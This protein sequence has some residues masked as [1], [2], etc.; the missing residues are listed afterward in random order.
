MKR[1][2][3]HIGTHKTGTTSIQ[4]FLANAENHLREDGILY[5]Q[6]GRPNVE[7]EA[8]YGHHVLAWAIRKKKGVNH[9]DDWKRVIDEID[10]AKEQTVVLS[11]ED[12]ETCTKEQIAHIGVLLESFE[13]HIVLFLRNPLDFLVSAYKQNIKSGKTAESFDEFVERRKHRC[14]YT[15][16]VERW[17][18]KFGTDYLHVRVFEK[19][20]DNNVEQSI[21]DLLEL[22]LETYET[23]MQQLPANVS[24][25]DQQIALV[26]K[27]NKMEATWGR[28]MF[29]KKLRRAILN[30]KRVGKVLLTFTGPFLDADLFRIDKLCCFQR[31]ANSANRALLENFL[32]EEDWRHLAC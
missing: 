20:Q 6:S 10:T 16:L 21:L 28:S 32:T 29:W 12:F 8:K 22:D 3:L 19:Y 5:P 18:G 25:S 1:I 27:I 30:G 7:H 26:Q 23:Y 14:N 13:V 4:K 31:A 17:A 11:S 24:P 9:L 2:F 15:R